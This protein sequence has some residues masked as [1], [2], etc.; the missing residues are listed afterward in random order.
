MTPLIHD[1]LWSDLVSLCLGPW[2]LGVLSFAARLV[3]G[4]TWTDQILAAV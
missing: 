2:P 3:R 4:Q 1:K